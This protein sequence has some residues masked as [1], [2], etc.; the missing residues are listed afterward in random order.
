[1]GFFF[2]KN[3]IE[4]N[5]RSFDE[6][7]RQGMKSQ[8]SKRLIRG[9][10]ESEKERLFSPVGGAVAIDTPAKGFQLFII[11]TLDVSLSIPLHSVLF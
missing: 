3:Q 10:F 8:Q 6:G 9:S 5:K 1:M 4:A 2:K 7:V 11:A